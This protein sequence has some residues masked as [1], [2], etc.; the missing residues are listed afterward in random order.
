MASS[1]S[2]PSAASSAIVSIERSRK[3]DRV[4]RPDMA[5]GGIGDQRLERRVERRSWRPRRGR[6]ARRPAPCGGSPCRGRSDQTCEILQKGADNPRDLSGRVDGRYMAGPVQFVH[7]SRD[8][9]GRLPYQFRGCRLVGRSGQKDDRHGDQPEIRRAG[10]RFQARGTSRCSLRDPSATAWSA[11]AGNRPTRETLRKTSGREPPRNRGQTSGPDSGDAL[12]PAFGRSDPC[13]RVG[14]DQTGHPRRM[15]DRQ[16]LRRHA[17]DRTPGDDGARHL[18]PVHQRDHVVR[19]ILDGPGL[20]LAS[21]TSRGPACR[22]RCN[23]PPAT[24]S[25][26]ASHIRQSVP[27]ELTNTTVAPPA[28]PRR[29]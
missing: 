20:R 22:T 2:L 8:Q 19:Q 4:A 17:A 15:C 26:T 29:R 28:A 6:H 1:S 9:S 5:P 25:I 11:R 21:L 18:Q 12:L 23:R 3:L 27:R 13:R 7:R 16:G 14:Q 24:A 10:R